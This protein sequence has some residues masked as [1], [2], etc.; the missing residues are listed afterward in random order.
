VARRRKGLGDKGGDGF[1]A[2]QATPPRRACSRSAGAPRCWTPRLTAWPTAVSQPLLIRSSSSSAIR[3]K[4]PIAKRPIGV[5]P[6]KLPSTETSRAPASVRRRI[7]LSAS[8]AERAKRSSRATTIPPVSPASQRASA[9]W[10]IG[11]SSLAPDWSI[12]S[13]K[14]TISTSCSLAQLSIFLR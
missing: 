3:I 8:I 5:E 6:S 4:I 9:C 12:S 7:E 2:E 14:R 11:R 10:N 1:V 13:Q